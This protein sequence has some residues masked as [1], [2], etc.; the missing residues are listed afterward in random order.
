[1][2]LVPSTVP[3]KTLASSIT[4]TASTFRLS[5]ILGWDGVALTS[6]AFG[7]EAYCV[8]RN[9]ARTQIEIMQ[10]SGTTI[11]S[12]DITITRRG[13]KFDGTLLTEVTANKL[14]WTKGDTL[15]DLG[16]DPPQLWQ[17]LKEYIDA[18]AIAGGV[19]ATTTVLGITKMSVAP[20]SASS[21]ISVGDNDPRLPL[22]TENDAM[23]GGSTFGTPSSTNKYITQDYNASATGA[24]VVRTYLNAASP[25]TWTK[26]AGLKYVVVEVQAAGGNGGN[27]SSASD[28][29]SGGGAGGYSK[30]L[31]AVATLG[32]TETVT[33]GA[34]GANSSFGS[35]ATANAGSNGSTG[36][37]G[38]AGGTSASGDINVKGGGGGA[39]ST[40]STGVSGVGGN[41]FFGS[42]GPAVLGNDTDGVAGG[43]YGGG[44]GGASTQSSGTQTGGAGGPAIV[45]VT[46]YYS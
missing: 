42:G 6:A 13:L 44:G 28:A 3:T 12:T 1:M 20:A 17:W 26:P 18:A 24:P 40:G 21:P 10:F 14:S 8:F 41:S 11:A 15:I 23:L 32:T 36:G 7:T 46:E 19:P 35:H 30:K 22:Q 37:V 43:N 5:D 45:T 29:G 27:A 38:G 9:T 4:S 33:I 34:V 39:G 31:I 25:A 2:S 16:T